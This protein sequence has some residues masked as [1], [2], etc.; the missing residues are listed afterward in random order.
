MQQLETLWRGLDV[1]MGS[2]CE[3]AAR[4]AQAV[5]KSGTHRVATDC[6]NYRYGRG[7]GL[8]RKRRRSGGRY[9]QVNLTT[10]QIGRQRRQAVISF[11]GPDILDLHLLALHKP[12]PPAAL[13]EPCHHWLLNPGRP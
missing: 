12:F 3:I 8:Q 7:C 9:D 10:N 6:K 2:T 11:V 5:D 13:P 1:D 4:P